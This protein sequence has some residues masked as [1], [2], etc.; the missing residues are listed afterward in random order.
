[1]KPEAWKDL[2]TGYVSDEQYG[3]DDLPLYNLD[4]MFQRMEMSILLAESTGI[5]RREEAN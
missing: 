3:E 4:Q 2:E 1:M 5:K